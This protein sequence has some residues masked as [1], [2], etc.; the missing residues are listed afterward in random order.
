MRVERGFR[1]LRPGFKVLGALGGVEGYGFQGFR[2]TAV[3]V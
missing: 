1:D 2:D 3:R